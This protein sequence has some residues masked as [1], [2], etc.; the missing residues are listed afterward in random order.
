M[1][2]GWAQYWN[3]LVCFSILLFRS[4]ELPPSVGDWKT[5]GLGFSSLL[6]LL[7]VERNYECNIKMFKIQKFFSPSM[8]PLLT[9]HGVL[10]HLN[11]TLPQ[12]DEY[13]QVSV[14]A[15]RP[16]SCQLN[17]SLFFPTSHPSWW[18]CGSEGLQPLLEKN[19]LGTLIKRSILPVPNYP[20]SAL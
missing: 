3:L 14:D 11:A 17:M 18:V 8:V 16:L 12:A 10:Y 13:A 1:R 4:L 20:T 9:L 7:R 5:L 19:I 15:Q 2:A 6:L